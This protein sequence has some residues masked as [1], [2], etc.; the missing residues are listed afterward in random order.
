[1]SDAL[2][3]ISTAAILLGALVLYA[4][5]GGADF[6]GG[7][8]DLLARGPRAAR[9][10]DVIAHALGPIWE[11]NHVWLILVVVLLFVGFPRAFAALATD[12]HI[13]LAVMLI[14][15]VLRGTAFT[16]RSYGG[17]TDS[18]LRFWGRV[19]AISST[20]TPL[21]LGLCAGA[22][23]SG[24]LRIDPKTG[25]V[26]TDF[27]SS[28]TSPVALA[29]GVLALALFAFLGAV[30]LTLETT[31]TDLQDDFRRRALAAGV[32][33][34]ACSAA[35]LLLARRDAP[36]LFEGLTQGPGRV[37]FQIAT[38][39]AAIAA[40]A[41]LAS[42]RFRLARAAAAVQVGLVVAGWGLAQFPLLIP[43][44]L[45]LANTAAPASVLRPM[46]ATLGVG[47][48]LL[49]PAFL[50]LFRVFKGRK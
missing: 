31:D 37:A 22:V 42:R 38:G 44:D 10:R 43:P 33:V 1:M 30:Y 49:G 14:G 20:V 16:F 9:Q 21:T 5:T 36:A 19:F 34:F 18:D 26:A 50:Y 47:S 25:L 7:V 35:A 32:V 39:T 17:G 13:P 11:A 3:Q 8:W 12:L 41:A 2:L 6:G 46:L 29:V 28:W 15:V 24:A 23:A 48:L 27:V 40:F 45:G 4:V